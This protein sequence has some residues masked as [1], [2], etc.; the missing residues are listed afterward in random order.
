M[1]QQSL[2]VGDKVT[3]NDRSNQHPGGG[4]TITFVSGNQYWVKLE[5][6]DQVLP[7]LHRW[8]LD[9]A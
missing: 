9:P 5:G 8:F 2:K 1:T 3:I 7:A 4:G 6:T